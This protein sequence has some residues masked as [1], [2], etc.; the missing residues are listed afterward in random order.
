MGTPSNVITGPGSLWVAAYGATLPDEA[1]AALGSAYQQV[2]YTEEGSAFTYEVTSEDITVAEELAPV[3]TVVTATKGMIA[4]QMAEATSRNLQIALNGGLQDPADPGYDPEAPITPQEPGQEQRLTLVLDTTE[5]ARWVLP[6]CVMTGS[7]EIA[8][9]KAPNKTLIP[10][11]FTLEL[12]DSG[13]LF[14]VYPNADGL[15]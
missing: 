10:V 14:T 6:K 12:P 3:R 9:R 5:G 1:G 15:I 2:G 11:E 7:L 4:F 8:R 13:P